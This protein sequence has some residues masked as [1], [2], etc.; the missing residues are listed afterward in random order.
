MK[1][2]SNCSMHI[3]KEINNGELV[4][5]CI[6]GKIMPSNSDDTLISETIY[7][8]EHDRKNNQNDID[9]LIMNEKTDEASRKEL[10]DC[11][12]CGMDY[13][14]MIIVKDSVLYVCEVCDTMLR[15]SEIKKEPIEDIEIDK[16]KAEFKVPEKQV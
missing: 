9:E 10:I 8:A 6:C 12:G 7:S 11:P 4:F 5:M 2:C 16:Q 14:V 1:F 15:P 3:K 13:M